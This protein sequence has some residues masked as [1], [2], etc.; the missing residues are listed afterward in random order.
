MSDKPNNPAEK[1]LKKSNLL[2]YQQPVGTKTERNIECI[3]KGRVQPSNCPQEI[4]RIKVCTGADLRKMCAPKVCPCD[5]AKRRRGFGLG[6]LLGFSAK[7]A[8][9]AGIFY[10]TYD[11]GIWGTTDDTQELCKTV[12]ALL[13]GPQPHKSEKW[14]PP[15]CQAARDMFT[16]PGFDPYGHCDAPPVS[17]GTVVSKMQQSWNWAVSGLFR[18][19]AGL[20]HNVIGQF[21]RETVKSDQTKSV[22]NSDSAQEEQQKP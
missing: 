5:P 12:C 18:G 21:K 6:R 9:A 22:H 15:S 8:I 20:P 7:A 2:V 1:C 17:F 10:V 3:S 4:K 16:A 13:K 19:L 14:D 11:M